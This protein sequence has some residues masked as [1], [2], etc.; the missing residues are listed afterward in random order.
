MLHNSEREKVSFRVVLRK[1]NT[2][3]SRDAKSRAAGASGAKEKSLFSRWEWI[4]HFLFHLLTSCQTVW[5]LALCSATHTLLEAAAAEL[6]RWLKQL[7]LVFLLQQLNRNVVTNLQLLHSSI[8]PFPFFSPSSP[9]Y[10]Q[11]STGMMNAYCGL[12]L[13]WSPHIKDIL[14]PSVNS[15]SQKVIHQRPLATALLLSNLKQTITRH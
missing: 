4:T 3:K 8:T 2:V 5:P 1:I 6:T 9:D 15:S 13:P 7:P 11:L 14:L 10:T 12:S